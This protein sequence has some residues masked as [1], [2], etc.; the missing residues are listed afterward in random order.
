[1][2]W[3]LPPLLPGGR[4]AGVVDVPGHERFIHNTLAGAAGMDLVLLGVDAG[5]GIMPQTREHLQI[6]QILGVQKGIV[7][8]TKMDLVDAEWRE[9]VQ[10]EIRDELRGTF[11]EGAPVAAVSAYTGE[12][13][14]A[15]KELIDRLTREVTPRDTAAPLRLPVDRAFSVPGFGTV[16]TGT[17]IQG[18][19]RTGETVAVIPPGV[20]ARVRNIQVHDQDLP[21][22][23]AGQRVALNLSGLEKEQV[24]RGS[25][26]AR[27]GFYRQTAL[28]DVAVSLPAAPRPL[29]NMD[30]VHFFLHRPGH[31]APAAAGKRY[32]KP[33]E[34]G[35][36]QCRRPRPGGGPR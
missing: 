4:L 21:E 14:A 20:E 32:A 28:V 5:E 9:L 19:V 8:I 35:L 36:A 7:V 16:I 33:G 31:G 15:L 24:L 25:V 6:L 30:P 27:P 26:V 3:G 23:R 2:T 29:K 17:L 13:I 10:E 1:M 22:A 12:G 11:L 34:K 18:T